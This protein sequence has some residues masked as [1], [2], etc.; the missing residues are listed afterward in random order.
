MASNDS[1]DPYPTPSPTLK[2]SSPASCYTGPHRYV[3]SNDWKEL[4]EEA[5]GYLREKELPCTEDEVVEL[6]LNAW[7]TALA[8][9]DEPELDVALDSHQ[10]SYLT[11]LDD[12]VREPPQL[13]PTQ[14]QSQQP[15][16]KQEKR[17]K[18]KKKSKKAKRQAAS[19]A[20][21]DGAHDFQGSGAVK[22]ATHQF[23]GDKE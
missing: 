9:E 7:V 1:Q 18:N 17:K 4:Y 2:P 10:S 11:L 23:F 15:E 12:D 8:Q 3:Y 20:A 22:P 16:S 6:V 5:A 14:P 21:K 13:I 19:E